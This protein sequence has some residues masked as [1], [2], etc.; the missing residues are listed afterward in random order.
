[1]KKA[2]TLH[3]RFLYYRR[4][5]TYWPAHTLVNA[6]LVVVLLASFFAFH[7]WFALPFAISILLLLELPRWFDKPRCLIYDDNI[8]VKRKRYTYRSFQM[9][10]LFEMGR[11]QE[12]GAEPMLFLCTASE[13]TIKR[14]S[15]K[16]QKEQI[17][18]AKHY[19]YNPND[20]SEEERQKVLLTLY[21]WKKAK[22]SNPNTAMLC[23]TDRSWAR[24]EAYRTEHPLPYRILSAPQGGCFD[25]Y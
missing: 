6:F 23:I 9:Q 8:T 7:Y 5:D 19:G 15:G 1:M 13:D 21:L 11:Y 22:M 20:L 3:S 24:L 12:D 16:H 18:V 25:E 10:E 4:K 2:L 17:L 14:F